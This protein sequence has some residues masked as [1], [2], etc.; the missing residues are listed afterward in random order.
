MALSTY[1]PSE[2]NVSLGGVP[3]SGFEVGTFVNIEKVEDT[4]SN[5]SGIGGEGIRIL[6]K[7]NFYTVTF[8]LIYSSASNDY[9]NGLVQADELLPGSGLVPILIED[10]L[11]RTSFSSSEAWVVKKA[12]TAFSDAAD[13][14]EWMVH[15]YSPQYFAAGI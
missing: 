12:T 2:I 10:G 3:I 11:G 5:K 8:T 14:R 15:V 6:K 1:A 9:L 7:D 13:P 4:W